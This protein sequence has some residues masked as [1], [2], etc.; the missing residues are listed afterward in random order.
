MCAM[1]NSVPRPTR[2]AATLATFLCVCLTVSLCDASQY[3]DS[4][5]KSSDTEQARILRGLSTVRFTTVSHNDGINSEY[6]VAVCGNASKTDPLAGVLQNGTT[7][8]GR[9]NHTS[10]VKGGDWMMMIFGSGDRYPEKYNCS[11]PR[12]A[13]VMIHC[14]HNNSAE[15]SMRFIK[16][17]R[18]EK[19]SSLCFF[20]LEVYSQLVCSHP[21]RI[22]G[23]TIITVLL[24]TVILVYIIGGTLYRRLILG[25]KGLEQIPNLVFWQAAGERLKNGCGKLCCK[26]STTHSTSWDNLGPRIERD[27]DSLLPP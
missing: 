9:V 1:G 19:D 26:P 3:C 24:L 16:E 8:L 6:A 22:G 11:G 10:V 21:D 14:N 4:K 13:F 7:V 27:D 23:G 15:N 18:E 12:Y 17:A 5:F 25:A 2:R 20:M